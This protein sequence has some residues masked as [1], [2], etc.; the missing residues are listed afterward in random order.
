MKKIILRTFIAAIIIVNLLGW[1]VGVYSEVTIGAMFRVSLI[2]GVTLIA[3]VFAGSA[4]LLGI[5]DK[6]KRD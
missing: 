6:E 5:L 4:A 1:L 3:T 2:L